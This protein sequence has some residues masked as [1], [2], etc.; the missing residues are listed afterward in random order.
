MKT[1]KIFRVAVVAMTCLGVC[2]PHQSFAREAVVV[3][4]IAVSQTVE[5][6]SLQGE[7]LVGGLVD[8][9]GKGVEDAPVLIAQ[10][11][12]TLLKLRTD[13][14]G[15]FAAKGIRPGVYQVVSHGAAG[16]YRVW[17][18]DQAPATAKR[19]VIHQVD[20]QIARGHSH[21]MLTNLLSNPLVI[22]GIIATAIA[23][24]LALDDDNNS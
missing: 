11:G 15:R 8:Q 10:N 16:N 14:E 1:S 4:G 3:N 22:A 18:A 13:S 2:F 19:G 7:T 23:M 6:L 20:P 12:K 5:D 21:S 9:N 24:P 17:S